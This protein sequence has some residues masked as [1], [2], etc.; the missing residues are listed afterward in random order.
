[1]VEVKITPF[2]NE[3]TETLYVWKQVQGSGKRTLT[4]I[5]TVVDNRQL[6]PTVHGI[7]ENFM[8]FMKFIRTY[9]LLL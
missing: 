3:T 8:K 7:Q 9:E 6:E 5:S 2:L 1:M 4:R